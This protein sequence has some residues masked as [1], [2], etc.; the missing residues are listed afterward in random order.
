MPTPLDHLRVLDLSTL[1]AGPYC[2]RLLAGLG[3]EVIKVEEPGLGDPTRSVGPFFGDVPDP[4][5][6]ALFS[7]LNGGKQSIT[8]DPRN[9]SG[10]GLLDDLIRKVDIV[11]ESFAPHTMDTLG[12]S[13]AH[14]QEIRS[15]LIIT[16]ITYFGQSGP[17]KERPA[18]E[19]TL[20]AEGGY[21]YTSGDPAREPLKPYG[22]QA[23]QVGGMQAGLAT[24]AA[25]FYRRFTG[26]GQIIDVSLQE[27]VAFLL[28]DAIPWYSYF[29]VPYRRHGSRV[30]PSAVRRNYSGNLL[31]C[32]DGYVFAAAAQNPQ[33]A[34]FLF[35]EP[36]FESSEYW[37]SAVEH[38]DEID[39]IC[40]NWLRNR[41]REEAFQEAQELNL[42]IAPV[43]TIAE[44]LENPQLASTEAFVE[45]SSPRGKFVS[46][47]GVPF[48]V[49][50]SVSS[51]N[52]RPPSLGEHNHKVFG[53]LLGLSEAE[54]GEL[55]SAG[56]V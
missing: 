56:V 54:L 4:E 53:D 10:R 23:Q 55:K 14:W 20:Q 49:S 12:M 8:L 2:T 32:K 21:L 33:M 22:Y 47:P 38:A 29:G 5:G 9:A 24:L 11:V 34:A 39:E 15:N 43:N 50:D 27:C 35:Q 18:S 7:Y 44:V 1:V 36:K 46:L 19:L 31:P 52:V 25:V 41:T 40:T 42:V 30:S 28:D 6:S 13:H 26:K 17:D 3:A 51:P 37:E 16:S 48:R 45:T